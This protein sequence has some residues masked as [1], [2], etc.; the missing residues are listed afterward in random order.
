MQDRSAATAWLVT[1][2]S[3]FLLSA[4]A[5]PLSGQEAADSPVS[6]ETLAAF[7]RAY[8]LIVEAREAFRGRLGRTHDAQRTAEI[9]K[10]FAEERARILEEHG[11][12]P[13]EFRRA[14]FVVSTD[15]ERRCAFEAMQRGAADGP[16]ETVADAPESEAEAQRPAGRPAPADEEPAEEAPRRTDAETSVTDGGADEERP[17][18]VTAEMIEAGRA[19]FSGPGACFSCH[20]PDG[21]G[22]PIGPNL[23]DET[24]LH[25]DGSFPAIVTLV[26]SGVPEPREH[27]A[28]MLPR[29]GTGIDDEQ[30]RAV[31]AYVWSL[32]HP[33]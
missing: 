4:S 13:E 17:A 19:V 20:G 3:L 22:T 25:V 6:E 1:L 8:P 26:E 31:A 24:W 11:L 29:G 5:A 16:G 27:P 33:H 10:E 7:A 32:T 9:R 23:T 30:V 2:A 28:P 12:T 18:E 15:A 14:T 21:T